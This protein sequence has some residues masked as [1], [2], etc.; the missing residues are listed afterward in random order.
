MKN[1]PIID[2]PRWPAMNAQSTP[3]FMDFELVLKATD[4]PVKYEDTSRQYRFEGFRAAAQ[5]Q[6]TI[7]VPATGFIFKTDPL[8][9]SRS[10]FAVLGAEVNGKYYEAENPAR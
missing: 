1:V 3:A 2:Q 5:L 4:Q 7:R 10:D 8:E 6:A 9:K